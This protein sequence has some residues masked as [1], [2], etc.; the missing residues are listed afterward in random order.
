VKIRYIA[1][2]AALALA[3]TGDP[4]AVAQNQ[5]DGRWGRRTQD[6]GGQHMKGTG[7]HRGEWLRQH[8]NMPPQEQERALRNDPSFRQ[9]PPDRQQQLVQRLRDFNN[10]PPEQRQR[11]LERMEPFEHLPQPQR[12]RLRGLYGQM[13]GLPDDRRVAVRQAVRQLGGM[14][15]ADRER[16]LNSPQFQRRYSPQERN[17]IRGLAQLEPGH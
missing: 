14:N 6:Q 10:R 12:E 5:R 11:M 15:P 8:Q 9:L 3:V 7:P 16:M 2:L 17:L 13:R 4:C 1:T